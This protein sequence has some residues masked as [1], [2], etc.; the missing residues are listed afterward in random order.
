MSGFGNFW[1]L[2]YYFSVALCFP[3][4]HSFATRFLLIPNFL[5]SCKWHA[6]T[7][8]GDTFL[9][10]IDFLKVIFLKIFCLG[11]F[12]VL[13]LV[14]L[15]FGLVLGFV[16]VFVVELILFPATLHPLHLQFSVNIP[17]N[18]RSFK[19]ISSIDVFSGMQSL[20][21]V[22]RIGFDRFG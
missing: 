8:I 11:L 16:F 7:T 22:W 21:R 2:F 1:I 18:K 5:V 17:T 4:F 3:S 6:D 14:F 13:V 20:A 15:F 12:F 9:A 10:L 19:A